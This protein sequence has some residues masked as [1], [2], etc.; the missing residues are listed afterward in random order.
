MRAL[1]NIIFYL[2]EGFFRLSELRQDSAFFEFIMRHQLKQPPSLKHPF[3]ACTNHVK[4]CMAHASCNSQQGT[5]PIQCHVIYDCVWCMHCMY[6]CFRGRQTMYILQVVL[7]QDTTRSIDE[8]VNLVHTPL[9]TM[10][11]P[12]QSAH[13]TDD[14]YSQVANA[15]H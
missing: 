4:P 15:W 3:F 9:S 6:M 11:P 10:I 7:P 5:H 12:G 14:L 8:Y 13:A 1:V 2:R